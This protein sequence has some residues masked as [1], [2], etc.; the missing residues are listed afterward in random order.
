MEYT[1]VLYKKFRISPFFKSI[2]QTRIVSR[3]RFVRQHGGGFMVHFSDYHRLEHSI[4]CMYLAE[5]LANK[6]NFTTA[7]RT[8][9]MLCALLHDIGH[10]PF[11]HCFESCE[12]FEFNHDQFRIKLL[13]NK[14]LSTALGGHK[15]QI[16]DI[17]EDKSNKIIKELIEGPF[18][19]DRMDYI[20][21]DIHYLGPDMK[22]DSNVITDIMA[23]IRMHTNKGAKNLI[24]S[25]ETSGSR[26]LLLSQREYMYT[27]FYK[28]N[29]KVGCEEKFKEFFSECS[30]YIKEYIH[31][32]K[33][34]EFTD[35]FILNM[36]KIVKLP[37][38]LVK[39][40]S[41]LRNSYCL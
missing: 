34:E 38:P 13:E 28:S 32:E 36:Y 12:G 18:G 30:E 3:L 5:K 25:R 37:C 27:H 24:Y 11:S 31:P 16:K 40:N 21:R 2:I 17:W 26:R 29:S 41:Q 4:G 8:L 23:G 33:W 7:D 19:V 39:L 10:G 9:M 20:M 35:D 14:E 22:I 6:L 15:S 1:D